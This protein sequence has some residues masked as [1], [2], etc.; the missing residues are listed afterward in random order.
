MKTLPRCFLYCLLLCIPLATRAQTNYAGAWKGAIEIPGMNLEIILH[1]QEENNTWVGYLD[2]P[3]QQV[4]D[5]KLAD[6][7]L[8]GRQLRFKLPEVP[9]NAAFK[10]SFNETGDKLDGT[11]SQGGQSFPMKLARASALEKAAEAERLQKALAQIRLL[12][13]SLRL[14]YHTPGLGL[15]IV[16]D[17]KVLLAEGFGYR[18]LEK[19]LP[20]TA[21]TQFAIGSSTKAF[22][23]AL[24]SVLSDTGQIDWH[25]PIVEYLPDF[26][27]YD[28]F[29]TREMTAED[30][31]CHR[32]GLPRHDVM[33][34]GSAF[35]RKDIYDRLRYLQPSKSFR[36]T[37]QYNNLMFMTA[38]YLTERISG[39]SWEKALEN[40]I[41]SP[42]GMKNS[43]TSVALMEKYAEPAK[44]YRTHNKNNT[45]LPYRNLDAVGPAG[46]INATV[47]DMLKWVNLH[48]NE[49]KYE[50]KQVLSAS[51]IAYLHQPKMLMDASGSARNPE[52][53]DPSYA[54][55]WFVHRHKGKLVV[56][57]GG[58]IDGFSALVYMLPESE[59][60]MVLLTNQDGSALTTLLSRYATDLLLGLEYTD[61][62]GRAGGGKE[63]EDETE[64]E[65]KPAP[66]RINGTRPAHE[67]AD[68]VGEYQHPGYGVV[69]I[70]QDKKGLRWQI[71]SF[72]VPL[73]H[74]HY[75]AFRGEVE[76][77][78]TSFLLN[79]HT[80]VSGAVQ[81]L[82]VNLEPLADDIIFVK[83][84]PLRL[85]DPVFLKGLTGKYTLKKA[86][87]AF[88]IELRNTTLYAK[89][90]GQPEYTLVPWQGTTFKLK[91]LS[92]YSVEF[93]LDEKGRAGSVVFNQPNG[94]FPAERTDN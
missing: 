93:L 44:G 87:M 74:W 41:F 10:G 80:D 20:V 31:V 21:N 26:K 2:I 54:A 28:E 39:Q 77:A 61:W 32:S 78:E 88:S 47:Q 9:G 84:A 76:E 30:L 56:H 17:G 66:K 43:N 3:L 45:L 62:N 14:L 1:L 22:T 71:N 63:E 52:L 24:L 29:A 6:L 7:A 34:Y 67:L 59:L 51:E 72:D 42:L 58:N 91:D 16:L 69:E 15:G 89:I 70:K 46:S 33:W 57:H 90:P 5:M 13:D 53:N 37:W 23:A 94:V 12:A 81:Q 38:G 50:G 25:K 75:E 49:G 73:E 27:L 65:E 18:D 82:S 48:L 85:S 8:E 68:Y 86:E 79:F 11:F 19:K 4:K 36:T 35:S 55:G 60:G 64:K 83:Q 40:E 92:G